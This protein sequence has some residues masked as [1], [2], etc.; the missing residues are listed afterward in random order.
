M[1]V[2]SLEKL[3]NEEMIDDDIILLL[4]FVT[5]AFQLHNFSFFSWTVS[6][7]PPARRQ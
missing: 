1:G 6:Q 4:K 2:V 5:R 7:I 3:H